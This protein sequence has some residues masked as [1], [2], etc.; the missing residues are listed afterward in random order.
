MFPG[1]IA[2]LT[3][4]FDVLG[5][6]SMR[7]ADGAMRDGLLYDMLGRFTDEDA[8]ERTV[9]RMQQRYHVDLAQAER[10]EATVLDFS[11]RRRG[12]WKLDDPLAELMLAGPRAARDRSR[13]LAQRLSPPRRL[14]AR[15]RGHA[16]LRARGA[17][18][19]REAGRGHRRKLSLE[20]LDDLVPPWDRNVLYLIVM[21]RLAVLL[22]RGR[23]ATALP[24]IRLHR[25][26]A[27][28]RDR[29]SGTLAQEH[30]LSMA[31]LQQEIQHLKPQGFRLR[32]FSRA[33]LTPAATSRGPGRKIDAPAAR[34][35][36][37][38]QA[39]G[40]ERGGYGELRLRK[41][42]ASMIS[43]STRGGSG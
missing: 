26:P 7:I 36:E 17:A 1:G 3:E 40:H 29:V 10:V 14:P 35:P 33:K 24:D 22:H 21:L 42:I 16:G 12:A 18:T 5:I 38:L 8:R 30:P 11:P 34:G 19:A 25:A 39:Y 2:I 6:E 31:D 15:E 4:V 28:A 20:G 41:R 32:V 43:S 37:S 27:V 23:S 13:R 9:R